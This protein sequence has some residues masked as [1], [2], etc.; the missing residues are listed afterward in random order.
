LKWGHIIP[1][2]DSNG[3][4]VEAKM[5]VYAGQNEGK[6]KQ[7]MTRISAEAYNALVDWMDLRKRDGEKITG[8]TCGR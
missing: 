3:E 5:V 4:V 1:E 7:Y 8:V 6:K 2:I